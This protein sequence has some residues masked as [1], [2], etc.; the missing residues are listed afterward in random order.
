M[1][2]VETRQAYSEVNM[3]LELLGD[4]YSSKIPDNVK[5]VFKKG[6]DKEYVPP[7]IDVNKPIK[8]QN[9]KRR[10]IAII[11]MLNL[12]YWCADEKAKHE[13]NAEYYENWINHE[14]KLREK[15]HPHDVFK[16]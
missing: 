15:Y 3:I 6:M 16:K 9:L 4:A 12:K 10:T 7:S 13:L 14:E 8:E 5:D 2:S 1:V 11:S